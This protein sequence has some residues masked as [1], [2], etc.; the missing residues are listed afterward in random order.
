M[1]LNI[2]IVL[3]MFIPFYAA[4]IHKYSGWLTATITFLWCSCT[5]TLMIL[6]VVLGVAQSLLGP[7]PIQTSLIIVIWGSVSMFIG[8]KVVL[9]D[10]PRYKSPKFKK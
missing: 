1:M 2:F 8:L 7:V 3:V 10:S 9:S 4:V 5:S 6:L